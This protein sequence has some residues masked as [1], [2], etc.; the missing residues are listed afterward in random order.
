MTVPLVIVKITT[1]QVFLIS[2]FF[3][4]G[5]GLPIKE[6]ALKGVTGNVW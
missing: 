6:E 2:Y 4:Y 5:T 1:K 3:A